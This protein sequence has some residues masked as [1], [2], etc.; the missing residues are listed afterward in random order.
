MDWVTC[1]LLT[2]AFILIIR[3]WYHS[4]LAEK[5]EE[6]RVRA[7]E[8]REKLKSAN[9]KKMYKDMTTKELRKFNGENDMPIFLAARDI[10]FDVTTNADSYGPDG[11][12]GIFAGRDAS[13]GL[14]KMSLEEEDVEE[15]HIK[16]FSTYEIETLDQ[17]IR[18]FLHK[19]KIVGRLLDAQNGKVP[20]AW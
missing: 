13:R 10:I 4:Y 2:I 18:M 8:R 7:E 9:R 15:C 6:R 12:Y 16:D 5:E 3:S 17:W 1:T 19:Y 14:G 20:E 11:G